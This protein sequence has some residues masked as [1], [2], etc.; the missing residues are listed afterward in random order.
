MLVERVWALLK[1][2]WG[3]KLGS[4]TRSATKEEIDDALDEVCESTWRQLTARVIYSSDKYT[5]RVFREALITDAKSW[6]L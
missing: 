3:K 2:L 5:E 1:R 6:L 4:I